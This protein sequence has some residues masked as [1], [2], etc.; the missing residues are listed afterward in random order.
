[1]SVL[2]VIGLL[3]T[4]SLGVVH[5]QEKIKVRWYVGLGGGSDAPTIPTRVHLNGR[6]TGEHDRAADVWKCV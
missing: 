3:A 6:V 2:L 4:L 1:L 5:A